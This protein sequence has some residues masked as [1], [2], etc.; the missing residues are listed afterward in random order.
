MEILFQK[1][2]KNDKNM[3]ENI[4]RTD[5]ILFFSFFK[6]RSKVQKFKFGKLKSR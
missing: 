5:D 4:I 6:P 2:K 3:M 1:K